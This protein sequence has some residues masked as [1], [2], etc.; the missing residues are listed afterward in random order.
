MDLNVKIAG[1]GDPILC[2][3][4]HPGSGNS[5]SVFTDRLSQQFQTFAPD[6]R[7]YGKSRTKQNFLMSDHID[8]LTELLD[9]YQID[10]C[11]L[12]GWS[13]GGILAIELILKYPDRFS[14]LILI[15]SS[16]R[17][18]SSHPKT[19]WFDL[20]FTGIAGIV[21][22]LKPGWRW[23]I[24]LF[25]K[26]SLFRYLIHQQTPLAYNYL[27]AG[28]IPAYFRTSAAATKALSVALKA[29]YNRLDDIQQIEI[30][31]LILAGDR[32]RHITAQSSQE[33]AERLQNCQ[34][35]CYA[36]TAHL[37]PWEIPDR[38]LDDIEQ[39]LEEEGLGVR[40]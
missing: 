38:V 26:R 39:W 5:M 15:A 27:A 35:H 29:G 4:G 28:G 25:G 3:H 24:N 17:P 14:G 19:S 9:R 22:L 37:F 21:N 33:T 10:R 2:L 11:L 32:D 12:L 30:P 1:K 7:G 8:D 34:W 31:C 13:L 20:L 23:N 18:W 6:L 16:A 36:D 40:G